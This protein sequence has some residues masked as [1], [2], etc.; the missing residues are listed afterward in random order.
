MTPSS[1]LEEGLLGGGPEATAQTGREGLAAGAASLGGRWGTVLHQILKETGPL[2]YP[3]PE[4]N[5]FCAGVLVG[6]V[7]KGAGVT[8]LFPSS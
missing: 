6:L 2:F 1:F 3:C 4:T 7:S 8:L 5:Q